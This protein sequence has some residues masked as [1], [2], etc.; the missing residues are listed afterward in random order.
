M[1][2]FRYRFVPCLEGLPFLSLPLPSWP[3]IQLTAPSAALPTTP[4]PAQAPSPPTSFFFYRL[5]TNYVTF[6]VGEVLLLILTICSLAAIFPRVRHALLGHRAP[7]REQ[8][9]PGT[10]ALGELWPSRSLQVAS[11]HCGG[12]GIDPFV[13]HPSLD[14]RPCTLLGPGLERALARE[15]EARRAAPWVEEQRRPG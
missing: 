15:P 2:L 4:P 11:F 9:S 6:V 3:L 5:M 12:S 10:W 1:E 8:P 7:W 14:C 13:H